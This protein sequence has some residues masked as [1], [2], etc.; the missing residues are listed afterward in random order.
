MLILMVME[1][2]KDIDQVAYFRFATVYLD[3]E[4]VNDLEKL[5]KG[6]KK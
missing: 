5:L 4:S 1:K 3:V 6:L 2:L